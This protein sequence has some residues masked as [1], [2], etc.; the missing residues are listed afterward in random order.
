MDCEITDRKI[1]PDGINHGVGTSGGHDGKFVCPYK[2]L[3]KISPLGLHTSFMFFCVF[4][5]PTE[6]Y[7][8]AK[9]TCVC[10]CVCV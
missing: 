1:C 5:G 6:K 2:H 10:R 3:V 4:W 7:T 8:S 9:E